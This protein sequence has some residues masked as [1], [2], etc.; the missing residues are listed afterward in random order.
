MVTDNK[1]GYIVLLALS[2]KI[3]GNCCSPYMFNRH[4]FFFKNFP[5]DPIFNGSVLI[6]FFVDLRQ[7]CSGR[8]K[9]KP[10]GKFHDPLVSVD[11]EKLL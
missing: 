2:E 1:Q 8:I 4:A 9:P 10:C 3:I 5:S 7:D 11:N 6:S